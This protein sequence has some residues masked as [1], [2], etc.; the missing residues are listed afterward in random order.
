MSGYL[1]YY[2]AVITLTAFVFYAADKRKAVKKNWRIPESVLLGLA[3]FGGG[4]GALL[5]MLV[6]RHKTQKRKFKLLVPLFCVLWT[7][8]LIYLAE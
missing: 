2:L 3:A 1:S 7:V 4:A 5:G 6:F 8:L